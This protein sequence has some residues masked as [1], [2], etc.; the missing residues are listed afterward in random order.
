V[1]A[2]ASAAFLALRFW[3][4]FWK[5]LWSFSSALIRCSSLRTE[6]VRPIIRRLGEALWLVETDDLEVLLGSRRGT[7]SLLSCG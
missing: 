3:S 1:A 4:Y 5:R 2:L 6:A 7:L